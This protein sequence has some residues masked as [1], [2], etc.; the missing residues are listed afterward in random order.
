MP[1]YT[2]IAEAKTYIEKMNAGIKDKKWIIWAISDNNSKEILGTI[3]IWNI[4][5]EL[6]TADLGYGLFSESRGRGIMSEAIK[7]VV[8]YGFN[9]MGLIKIVAC[10]NSLNQKS[11]ALLKRNGFGYSSTFEEPSSNGHI[12]NMDIYSIT[13]NT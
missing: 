5:L 3:S 1:V 6:E 8:S 7:R 2:D 13:P 11:I 4:S 10:T 9:N 12:V